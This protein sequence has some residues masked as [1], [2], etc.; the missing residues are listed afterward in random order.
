MPKFPAR[1][2]CPCGPLPK[3]RHQSYIDVKEE[4][5]LTTPKRM[6]FLYAQILHATS[7]PNMFSGIRIRHT[8]ISLGMLNV[9]T[10][11][12]TKVSL[13]TLISDFRH[14]LPLELSNSRTNR[15]GLGSDGCK[16]LLCSANC[17]G[18]AGPWHCAMVGQAQFG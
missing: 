1:G 15:L 6:A 5:M 4:L 12:L 11:H 13:L 14:Y 3:Y 7:I 8:N 2:N 16:F 9:R 17:I 18:A 10:H